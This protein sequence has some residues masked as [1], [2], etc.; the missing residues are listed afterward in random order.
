M[1]T[2][3]PL[4]VQVALEG[5]DVLKALVPDVFRYAFLGQFLSGEKLGMHA[6]D[7]RLL[8]VAAVEN[9]DPS[10]LRQRF[11]A[12]PQVVVIEIFAVG[13]LK[14]VT[15]QPCGFTPDMTCLIVPS[16]PAAS[17]AWKM[18]S[19]DQRSCA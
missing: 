3:V 7:E 15:W 12:A 13:A 9:A 19:I 14:E 2:I 10:A 1:R 5:A 11:H 18:S 8:V 16:F 17:I 4:R 6:H